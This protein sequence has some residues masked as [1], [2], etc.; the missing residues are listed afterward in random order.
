MYSFSSTYIRFFL[1]YQWLFAYFVIFI[2]SCSSRIHSFVLHHARKKA[3]H[4]MNYLKIKWF[5]PE[6][7]KTLK[8]IAIIDELIFGNQYNSLRNRSKQILSFVSQNTCNIRLVHN[9]GT[10]LHSFLLDLAIHSQHNV[11]QPH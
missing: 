1:F 11:K 7:T 3:V 2:D 9:M 5:F 6:N 4:I 8:E 10:L